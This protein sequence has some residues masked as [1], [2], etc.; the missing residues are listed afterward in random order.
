MTNHIAKKTSFF[1]KILI[2]I[3]AVGIILFTAC[4]QSVEPAKTHNTGTVNTP[5]PLK[6]KVTVSTTTGGTVETNPQLLG[7]GMIKENTEITFTATPKENYTIQKWLVNGEEVNG[8]NQTYKLKITKETVIKVFFVYTGTV[9]VS[10]HKISIITTTGGTVESDPLLPQDG[11]VEENTEITFTA[12]PKENYAIQKWLVNGE[13]VNDTN[14]TYKLKITKETVIKVFFAYTGTVPLKTHK[15]SLP[16]LTGGTVETDPLLPPDGM[17]EE[18]T[19]ITFTAV[20]DKG[21]KIKSWHITGA[22]FTSGTGTP[23]NTQAKCTVGTS[24]IN[25]TADFIAVH[26]VTLNTEGH[27]TVTAHPELPPDG[28]VEENTEIT[29]TAEPGTDCISITEKWKVNGAVKA[30]NTNTYSLI[31]TEAVQVQ[32][33]FKEIPM[34][35]LSIAGDERI[36]PFTVRVPQGK[37]WSEIKESVTAKLRFKPEWDNGDYEVLEW[38]VPPYNGSGFGDM[39]LKSDRTICVKTNYTKFRIVNNKVT[40]YEGEKPRGEITFKNLTVY[41]IERQAFENC[42][43]ITAVEFTYPINRIEFLAFKGCTKLK[44][45]KLPGSL[46]SIYSSAFEGCSSLT[47]INFDKYF[48]NDTRHVSIGFNAFKDCTALTALHFPAVNYNTIADGAFRNCTSLT[49]ISFVTKDYPRQTTIS[50]YAFDGCT[51]LKKITLPRLGL[52]F[53]REDPVFEVI[54]SE[55]PFS[56]C[57][58]IEEIF[59]PPPDFYDYD[60][61]RIYFVENNILYMKNP[62]PHQESVTLLLAPR[63]IEELN[64]KSNT[65]HIKE[66]A[67]YG[68]QNLKTI[69]LPENLAV[70]EPSAFSNCTNLT[71]LNLTNCTKME[72]IKQEAFSNCTK[73][74]NVALP[75]GIKEIDSKAFKNCTSL[76]TLNI[77]NCPELT[78]IKSEAFAD[79]TKLENV[80]LPAE[81]KEIDSKAFKNCTSLTTLNITNCLKLETIKNEAFADCTKLENLTLPAGIKEIDSY[82]FRNCTGLTTL[83][84]TNCPE[85][86]TIKHGAFGG[87]TGLTTLNIT[88]CPELTTIEDWAFGDCTGLTTLNIAKC[89]KLK[90]IEDYTFTE[91]EAL[92]TINIHDSVRFI[93]LAS[94]TYC[95]NLET[96]VLP[97]TPTV[98]YVSKGK[99]CFSFC[100]KLK[101]VEN[102]TKDIPFKYCKNLEWISLSNYPELEKDA[103]AGFKNLKTVIIS[104]YSGYYTR[105]PE[106]SFSDCSNLESVIIKSPDIKIDR[107][108][109]NNTPRTTTFRV[110]TEEVKNNLLSCGSNIAPEQITVTE[111][112]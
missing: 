35:T 52:E 47:T 55:Q 105:I 57:P 81:I 84:I 32:A 86:T 51:G 16:A 66:Q 71:T 73:L 46:R 62:A 11:T 65:T 94:F 22:T 4:P 21:Y 108:A 68:C 53:K 70:I 82:A 24:E 92:K 2:L 103:F 69:T 49:E 110:K 85:L 15:I 95:I 67:F 61:P 3:A 37:T 14:K 91:C 43:E 5:A 79:C 93:G 97:Q 106:N 42:T 88:N 18:N 64:I 17:V 41:S 107:Y 104:P 72:S 100:E 59:M 58:N 10:K 6:H 54:L 63:T 13:E 98:I 74:E 36:M 8:T 27:G 90:A 1:T 20:P 29:F 40:G 56:N 38:Y 89:P 99:C 23:G 31:V 33:V 109:F 102:L 9:P 101:K 44:T 12:T 26:K 30:K 25:V 87:C 50:S 34:I 7:N 75:A 45:I 96:L 77:T 83:N 48:E 76:T 111:N 80:A 39:V 60:K 28:M 78:T 19:E 112:P